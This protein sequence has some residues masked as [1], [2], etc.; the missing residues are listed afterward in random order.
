MGYSQTYLAVLGKSREAILS[1]LALRPTGERQDFPEGAVVATLLPSGWF[2]VVA[3]YN[4]QE[5]I[6]EAAGPLSAG[7]EVVSG[8][9]EEHVM[10]SE[11]AGWRNGQRLWRVIHDTQRKEG[12]LEAEGELPPAFEEIRD[13]LVALQH[14]NDGSRANCDYIFDIPVDLVLSLTGY[15]YDKETPGLAEGAFE[16]LEANPGAAP[17]SAPKAPAQKSFFQ[18]IFGK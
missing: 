7:C 1:D 14:P 4:G 12:H 15:R 17:K 2:L 11:A 3:D 10:V 5:L 18:R 13:R 8:V 16:V 6:S 9:A